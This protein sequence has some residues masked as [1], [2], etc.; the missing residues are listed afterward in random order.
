MKT[1]FFIL[2]VSI[3]LSAGVSAEI[4]SCWNLDDSG[5]FFEDSVGDNHGSCFDYC[6]VQVVGK[7][8]LRDNLMAALF[9]I[10]HDSH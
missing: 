5:N 1:L 10:S 2:I 4:I 3:M 6:P 8:I 9:N 7:L